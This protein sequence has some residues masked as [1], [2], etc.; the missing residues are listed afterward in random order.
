[1]KSILNRKTTGIKKTCFVSN[2]CQSAGGLGEN[3]GNNQ[4]LC[5]VFLPAGCMTEV[6]RGAVGMCDGGDSYSNDNN[7]GG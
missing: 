6:E 1:M 3:G 2:L 5:S 4:L 7:K